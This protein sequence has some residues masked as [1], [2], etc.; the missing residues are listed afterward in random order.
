V[1]A[2]I[3]SNSILQNNPKLQPAPCGSFLS[4]DSPSFQMGRRQ[5]SI[6]ES[7]TGLSVQ[8]LFE[9]EDFFE[10]VIC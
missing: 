2:V 5:N 3:V 6:Q 10:F 8:P 9:F 7:S 1:T 4:G